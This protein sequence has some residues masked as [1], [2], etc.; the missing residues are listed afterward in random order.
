MIVTGKKQVCLSIVLLCMLLLITACRDKPPPNTVNS[1]A[2]VPGRDIGVISGSASVLLAKELGNAREYPTGDE[3]IY[4]LITGALDCVIMED[5][6]AAELVSDRAGIRI[7]SEPLLRYDLRFAT[8]KENTQ[9]LEAVNS[10]LTALRG[11]GTLSGLLGKYFSGKNYSYSPPGNVTPHPGTLLLAVPADSPPYS[12]KD[13]DGEFTGLDIEVAQAVCDFLGVE[14]QILEFE[15]KELVTA[16]W[17]GKADLAL[18]WIPI[19]GEETIAISE[20]YAD[21]VIKIIVRK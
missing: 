6:A 1:P 14:L 13:A 20:A 2:D 10:A 19:D 8:A 15:A 18:G 9:L 12:Y 11:N 3:L 21:A 4:Q 7:L 17:H 5:T 16:V